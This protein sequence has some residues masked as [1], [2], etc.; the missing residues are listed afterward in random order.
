MK[1]HYL[2]TN[3]KA[4][5]THE[6][7]IDRL[8][9]KEYPFLYYSLK[10]KEIN[11]SLIRRSIDA[12]K[13]NQLT[14]NFTLIIHAQKE[15]PQLSKF[16]YFY[17]EMIELTPIALKDKH[18]F[19]IGMGPAGLFCALEL[20]ERGFQPYIFE[21]GKSIED[22]D[23]DVNTFW[24]KGILNTE[25]NVQFGEGGAGT[26]SDGKL[27]ARN[28]GIYSEKVF[29]YLIRHG[30]N[31]DIEI[32]AL[33][34]LGTDG[35]KKILLS[36]RQYLI[37]KG[38][39]I[40]FNSKLSEISLD[41]GKVTDVLINQESYQPEAV[42]LAPGNSARD[43]FEMLVNKGLL[44]ESKPFA[45]GF[46]IEH[47]QEFINERFYGKQTDFNLTGPAVYS[48]TAQCPPYGVY[49]FCMCPGGY[50]IPAAS[51][52][53]NQVVNGMSNSM[54]DNRFANSAIVAT[55]NQKD[56]GNKALDGIQFQRMIE[57]RAF[58]TY[59]CPAQLAGDFIKNKKSPFLKNSSYTLEIYSKNLN[60][61]YPKA[62]SQALAKGLSQF[63]QKIK[64]FSE[65][66]LLL[67]PETRTSCPVRIVREES[68][69]CSVS[70]ENLYP[71]GEGA[72]YAGGIVS[73]AADG[74]K[75]AM[76]FELMK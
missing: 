40:F 20:V 12:R 45:V 65:E 74:I 63:D 70:A 1:Y 62:I 25:S 71:I 59:Q 43:T 48:L 33:P 31:P 53:G 61:L 54:R 14:Y 34:H 17:P 56:F 47:E 30:A 58:K 72:G 42:I 36:V 24:Q 49:S 29:Q 69:G 37:S 50:V 18:P 57:S 22:R 15:I 51:E 75:L 6:I 32:N 13:R 7:K 52:N 2:I 38:C 21:R 19:I 10:S 16:Q 11:Y 73:S 55:V 26:F 9:T 27:T 64:G 76:R 39:R 23:Q 4:K 60:E 41:K 35:L 8:L 3:L 28:R 44:F 46:R 68:K 67:A 5:I 66:G